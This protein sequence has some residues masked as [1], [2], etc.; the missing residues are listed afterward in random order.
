MY[1]L[2]TMQENTPQAGTIR[3]LSIRIP[4]DTPTTRSFPR[5]VYNP[6][7]G[8]CQASQSLY[9][10]A[11]ADGRQGSPSRTACANRW[12]LM[13]CQNMQLYERVR[14]RVYAS[15][16]LCVTPA[17]PPFRKLLASVTAAPMMCRR[18]PPAPAGPPP[19]CLFRASPSPN[20]SLSRLTRGW[21][22]STFGIACLPIPFPPPAPLSPSLLRMQCPPPPR[23][24]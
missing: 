14:V 2:N 11:G 10:T 7:P 17:P 22:W 9:A 15:C 8:G 4:C 1:I 24:P 20:H 3:N 16:K 13:M 12:P 19:S 6:L 23:S 21:L 18:L 5:P